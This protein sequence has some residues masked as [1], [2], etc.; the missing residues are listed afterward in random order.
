PIATGLKQNDP[1]RL[2]SW[3]GGDD[4]SDKVD[5][6]KAKKLEEQKRTSAQWI[7][8][9]LKS[10]LI[11]RAGP[12][13]KRKG[14]FSKK[15]L[16]ILTDFPRLIYVDQEKMEQKGEIYWSSRMVVELKTKKTFFVHT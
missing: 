14:L 1:F 7:P 11:I 2:E 8:F 10:E 9:L 12:I 15:R 5:P 16:L 6:E 3:A 13:N 4:G